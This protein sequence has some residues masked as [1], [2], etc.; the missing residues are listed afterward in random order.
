MN[1][2]AHLSIFDKLRLWWHGY[3]PKHLC[4]K[5]MTEPSVGRLCPECE[6]EHMRARQDAI[7]RIAAKSGKCGVCGGDHKDYMVHGATLPP[8]GHCRKR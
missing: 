5:V 2:R 3:C 1:P 4:E 8:R 7:A 6:L